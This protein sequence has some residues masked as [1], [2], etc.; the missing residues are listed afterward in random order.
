MSPPRLAL[1]PAK[2]RGRRAM[3]PFLSRRRGLRATAFVIATVTGASVASGVAAISA[4]AVADTTP[5]VLTSVTTLP[6]SVDVTAGS[7]AIGVA[8]H[9]TDDLSGLASGTVRDSCTSGCGAVTVLTGSNQ[10]FSAGPPTDEQVDISLTVPQGT[11]D[12]SSWT[13]DSVVLNDGIGNSVTYAAA[14]TGAEVA[15]PGAAPTFDVT[16]ISDAVAPTVS[17]V[18]VLGVTPVDVTTVNKTVGFRVHVNDAGS[19]VDESSLTLTLTPSNPGSAEQ[20]ISSFTRVSGSVHSGDYESS[21]DSPA[22]FSVQDGGTWTISNIH[23][24][25]L[26]AQSAD[27][28]N[29]AWPSVVVNGGDADTAGPQ[30]SAG[31]PSFAAGITPAGGDDVSLTSVITDDLTGFQ[32]GSGTLQ[33][34]AGPTPGA[35][36]TTSIP[37]DISTDDATTANTYVSTVHMPTNIAPGTYTL[38]DIS[39]FDRAGNITSFP[40]GDAGLPSLGVTVSAGPAD[41]GAP[42]VASLQ[43]RPADVSLGTAL[44][45]GGGDR[46]AVAYVTVDDPAADSGFDHG[47]IN[48]LSPTPGSTPVAVP[49]DALSRV[50]GD[51]HAGVYR[52]SLSPG[53][54]DGATDPADGTYTVGSVD[55]WSRADRDATVASH[56]ANAAAL[57]ALPSATRVFTVVHADGDTEAPTIQS[58]E[59]APAHIDTTTADKAVTV[60]VHAVDTGTP[61]SGIQTIDVTL[62]SLFG[63]GTVSG[64]FGGIADSLT[65]QDAIQ[66]GDDTDGT[67]VITVPVPQWSTPGDWTLDSASISDNEANGANYQRTPTLPADV[68]ISA[69][70]GVSHGFTNDAVASDTTA[71]AVAAITVTEPTPVAATDGAPYR[72]HGTIELTDAEAGVRDVEVDLNG[73]TGQIALGD[74]HFSPAGPA[75]D[76]TLPWSALL[77]K[78]A[79]TGDWAISVVTEDRAGNANTLLGAFA[80][81]VPTSVAV[82]GIPDTTAPS[83]ADITVPTSVDVTAGPV[84]AV[85]TLHVTDDLSGMADFDTA[86]IINQT[87]SATVT[88]GPAGSSLGDQLVDTHVVGGNATDTMLQAD[89]PFSQFG[90]AGDWVVKSVDLSDGF[91][92]ASGPIDTSTNVITVT[93]VADTQAPTLTSVDLSSDTLNL[94]AGPAQVTV[95]AHLTDDASGVASSVVTL[96]GPAGQHVSASLNPGATPDVWTG[97]ATIPQFSGGGAWTLTDLFAADVAGN[98]HDYLSAE[99]AGMVTPGSLAFTGSKDTLAPVLAGLQLAPTSVAINGTDQIVTAT[100]HVVDDK[101]GLAFGMLTLSAPS[102]QSAS[103]FFDPTSRTDGGTGPDGTY[104]TQLIVPADAEVGSW[105]VSDVY[106]EDAV[107][108]SIDLLPDSYPTGSVAAVNVTNT[109]P[110]VIDGVINGV[111]RNAAAAPVGGAPVTSCPQNARSCSTV[112]TVAGGSYSIGHLRDDSYHLYATAPQGSVLNTGDVTLPSS[113]YTFASHTATQNFTLTA[114][115]AMPTGISL[116]GQSST[117]GAPVIPRVMFTTPID[118][119]AAPANCQ[120]GTGSITVTMADGTVLNETASLTSGDLAESPTGS[121]HFTVSLPAAAPTHGTATDSLAFT[122]GGTARAPIEFTLY[123]DP[124][125]M[126]KDVN[127]GSGIAGV[128]VTLMRSSTAAGTYSP[129]ADGSDVMSPSNRHNPD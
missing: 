113:L 81:G 124:S 107:S 71:P 29:P 38:T 25:D 79:V 17:S 102:G 21:A 78:N 43:T 6:S 12:G 99:L 126:V 89:I 74:M 96:T 44:S 90:Q 26:A 60:T 45:A 98:Q 13:V 11:P 105:T 122:C 58:I 47:A 67:Y 116:N 111:V 2:P 68:D 4:S 91:G 1:S 53:L 94:D 84:D 24:A 39:L 14:P 72:V 92:N 64:G 16:Q 19:G 59:V 54:I 36:A 109:H 33:F 86:D 46:P 18:A 80:A 76:V 69:I 103:N 106:L 115:V 93:G 41:A 10:T 32:S 7:G 35:N 55:M 82:N 20:V 28:S 30:L 49:F 5:P 128:N 125:G 77:P 50:S 3:N 40:S 70:G 114:P 85:V 117:A 112:K 31:S 37:F 34:L 120:N 22:S 123:I 57:D 8:L 73:P 101:S 66:A 119:T 108:N 75:A 88:Y 23:V 63:P 65:A 52:V 42:S 83:L 110:P 87:G 104:A 62:A 129:V 97:V 95:D 56:S 61:T 9:V 48:V 51:A 100:L 127:S 121:G 15:F 27:L 118:V